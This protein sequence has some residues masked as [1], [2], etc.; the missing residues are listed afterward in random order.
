M[1]G[2]VVDYFYRIETTACNHIK[3]MKSM[4]K[5]SGCKFGQTL[6]S[7]LPYYDNRRKHVKPAPKHSGNKTKKPNYLK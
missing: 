1:F 4:G 5:M 6:V 7:Q 2:L 3:Y